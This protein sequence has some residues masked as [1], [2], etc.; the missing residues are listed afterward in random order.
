MTQPLSE[1]LIF[2]FERARDCEGGSRT[3]WCADYW[4]GGSVRPEGGG[5]GSQR[6]QINLPSRLECA[7]M[8]QKQLV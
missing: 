2:H 3:A 5:G 4:W 1:A 7:K 8:E 6:S